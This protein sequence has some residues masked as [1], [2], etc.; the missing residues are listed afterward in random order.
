VEALLVIAVPLFDRVTC[1]LDGE[2]GVTQG[3]RFLGSDGFFADLRQKKHTPFTCT[4]RLF[5]HNM[6]EALDRADRHNA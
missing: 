5:M 1:R 6:H 2:H 3:H 4:E